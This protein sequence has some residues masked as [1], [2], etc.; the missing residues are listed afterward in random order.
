MVR[1]RR[2]NSCSIAKED[3]S[4]PPNMLTNCQPKGLIQIFLERHI[5]H[6]DRFRI[7]MKVCLLNR[8]FRAF[9]MAQLSYYDHTISPQV[10]ILQ[11]IICY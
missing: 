4:H 2:N 1:E 3:H 6:F 10:K 8:V 5:G 7:R 11:Y 9:L